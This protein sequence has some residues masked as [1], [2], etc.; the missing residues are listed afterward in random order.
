MHRTGG[1]VTLRATTGRTR[2]SQVAVRGSGAGVGGETWARAFIVLSVGGT[3]KVGWAG[4]GQ[5]AWNNFSEV[6]T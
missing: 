5:A 3:D 4:L 2:V 1:F 6:Q